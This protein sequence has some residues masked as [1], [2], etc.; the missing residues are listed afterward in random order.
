MF[1]IFR[2]KVLLITP[3]PP[4]YLGGL[5]LFSRDLALNLE[6]NGIR[7]DVLTSTLSKK[8]PIFAKLGENINVLKQKV[9]LFADN[10]NLLRIKN[11]LFFILKYLKKNARKYDLIHVHSYIYFSTIQIFIYKLLFNRKIP[12]I[13][14]LHG[15]IQTEEYI[16]SSKKEKIM[17]LL[18]KYLFDIFSGKFMIKT[19]NALISV[20]K[21]DL[22]AINKVFK[23]KRYEYNYYL[24]NVVDSNKFIKLK[25]IEKKYIGFIGRLTKIKGIDLFLKIVEEINK[26]DKEQQ[27]LIIGDGPY[28]K[29]VKEAMKKYPIKFIQHVVHDKMV[30]YYNQCSIFIQTSRAEGL[31]TCVLEALS[32]EVPVIA[33]NVGGTNEIVHNGKTGYLFEN[34]IVNEALEE[35]NLIKTN[36]MFDELGRNGRDLIKNKFSWEVITKKIILIYKKV[37]RESN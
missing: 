14:H 37:I 12:I 27:F 26:K 7:V 13:L 2:M 29:D 16:A 18:K 35:F 20:S 36:Q 4:E 34:G 1:N 21:D 5:A 24:P 11:P 28:I 8:G 32:C 3:S 22:L 30:E 6:K 33:S 31:P 17:L 15:G 25:D 19:A 23:I 10:N 9:H